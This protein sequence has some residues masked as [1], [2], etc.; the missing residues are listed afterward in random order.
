[1]YKIHEYIFYIENGYVAVYRFFKRREF[2]CLKRDGLIQ[3]PVT[4]DFWNWWKT[5]AEYVEE[6]DQMDFC[7]LCDQVE[8]IIMSNVFLDLT[9]QVKKSCW[10]KKLIGKF[11]EEILENTHIE[12][13]FSNGK[14]MRL[15]KQN[16][17]F[18]PMQNV[19]KIF[20]TNVGVET[21]DQDTKQIEGEMS[22]LAS[23]YQE[24][25]KKEKEI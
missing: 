19:K 3:F 18:N 5:S 1:M 17:L 24:K 13:C 2:R 8:N 7:F 6:T 9:N 14:S 20:Y 11:F 4:E 21:Y 12:V 23:Y 16:Q 25:I 10:N 15:D 22:L